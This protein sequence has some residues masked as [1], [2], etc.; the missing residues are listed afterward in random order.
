[1]GHLLG[2]ARVSTADQQPHLQVNAL[3][4][5]GCD[6][7]FTETASGACTDRPPDPGAAP[8]PG[9]AM[10]SRVVPLAITARL[11]GEAAAAFLTQPDLA[12]KG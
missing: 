6:R 12:A 1:M 4:A 2:V 11:V 10:P 7:V 5:A 9:T 8:G 3:T